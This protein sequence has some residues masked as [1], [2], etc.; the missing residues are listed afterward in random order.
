[1]KIA[2]DAR[3]ALWPT[4]GIGTIVRNV[5][6]RIQSIDRENEYSFYF[7]REPPSGLVQPAAYHVDPNKVRWANG[8]M[9]RELHAQKSQVFLSFLEKEVPLWT[10]STKVVC[11][12]HDLIPLRFPETV[13]RNRLHRLYYSTMLKAATSRASIVLTNSEHSRKE[14]LETLHVPEKKIRKITLGVDE[15]AMGSELDNELLARMGVRRPYFLAMGSTEPRK[16]NARVMEAF[17]DLTNSG[18]MQLVVAGAPWRG[19][20]FPAELS[21]PTIV[22]T[23]YVEQESLDCL[24]RNASALVFAS[25]HEGFGLPVLEAMARGVPVITSNRTA[26]PEVGGDA[27]LYVD[28]ESVQEIGEAM[29]KLMADPNLRADL[30]ARGRAQAAQFRWEQTCRELKALFDELA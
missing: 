9:R 2:I 16:N 22:T 29:A 13:F 6:E 1:M 12:V 15:A 25:L 14:I 5:V 3:P 8:Y 23:G 28:P 26:L 7:D 11:M 27:A 10:G 19:R 18:E 20:T 17:A 4:T 24:M 30:A 21:R